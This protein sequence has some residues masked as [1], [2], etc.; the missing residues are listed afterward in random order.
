M[1]RAKGKT[2]YVWTRG[3]GFGLALFAVWLIVTLIEISTSEFMQAVYTNTPEELLAKSLIWGT[4]YLIIG[5]II[6]VNRW[7]GMEE[8]Y[9]YLS[10]D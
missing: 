2:R 5:F 7:K 8:K 9:D 6:S 3:L 10:P 4:A 1:T